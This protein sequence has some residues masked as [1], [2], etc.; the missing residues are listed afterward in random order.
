MRLAEYSRDV[1]RGLREEAGLS[2]EQR[3]LGTLQLFR[4]QAQLDAAARQQISPTHPLVQ[5][6]ADRDW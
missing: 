5:P 2:Y 3:S 6:A 4:S 1:L